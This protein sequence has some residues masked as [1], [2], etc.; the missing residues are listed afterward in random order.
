MVLQDVERL[1]PDKEHG[2][3]SM[4]RLTLGHEDASAE[5]GY[6][7]EGHQQGACHWPLLQKE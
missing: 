1:D 4:T 5:E 2:V 6:P 3:S 7:P